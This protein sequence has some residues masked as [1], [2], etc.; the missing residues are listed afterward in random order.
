MIRLFLLI[1]IMT[2]EIG[3]SMTPQNP[4]RDG[5]DT[6]CFFFHFSIFNFEQK[7]LSIIQGCG[8]IA[9]LGRMADKAC[10]AKEKSL[11]GDLMYPCPNDQKVLTRL[12]VDGVQFQSM[13]SE[14]KNEDELVQVLKDKGYLDSQGESSD[15]RSTDLS[16]HSPHYTFSARFKTGSKQKVIQGKQQVLADLALDMSLASC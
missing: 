4:P 15:V 7:T 12:G 9:W 10:L 16:S 2:I 14:A 3:T 1:I 11:P 5:T 13:A 8:G 6:V